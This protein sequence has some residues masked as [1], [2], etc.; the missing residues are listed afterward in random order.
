MRIESGGGDFFCR[1]FGAGNRGGRSRPAVR[2]ILAAT[3]Q[4]QT[5]RRSWTG[6]RARDSGSTR[7]SDLGR[8]P[9]RRWLD[10]LFQ[11][12][13]GGTRWRPGAG[14]PFSEGRRVM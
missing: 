9:D 11:L 4:R 14:E 5:R 8:E 12:A 10:F 13:G 7:R 3:S 2:E 6:D 1:R